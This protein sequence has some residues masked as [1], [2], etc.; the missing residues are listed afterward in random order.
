MTDDCYDIGPLTGF[1]STLIN[2]SQDDR[3]DPLSGIGG[4]AKNAARNQNEISKVV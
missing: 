1:A 2:I 3:E 4:S